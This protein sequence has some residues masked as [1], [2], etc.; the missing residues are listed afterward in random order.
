MV[1]EQIPAVPLSREE[2]LT[3]IAAAGE[4][5]LRH[6]QPGA[7]GDLDPSLPLRERFIR[8]ARALAQSPATGSDSAR[9]ATSGSPLA[10][11][12]ATLARILVASGPTI[13]DAEETLDLEKLVALALLP[14]P[15]ARTTV[16]L[17]GDIRTEVARASLAQPELLRLHQE[18]VRVSTGFWSDLI[19][20]AGSFFRDLVSPGS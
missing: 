9:D 10:R 16:F 12:A 15:A 8:L 5:D 6:R 19:R 13:E 17:D 3:L 2:A 1:L 20:A 4:A 14:A 18:M 7:L 11:N